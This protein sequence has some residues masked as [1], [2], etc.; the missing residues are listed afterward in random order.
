LLERKPA[1][2]ALP[3]RSSDRPD[4]YRAVTLIGPAFVAAI[5]YVDPGNLATD[6]TG[7]ARFGYQLVW[8]VVLANLMAMLVQYL[9]AKLGVATGKNLAELCRDRYRTPV[10]VF[11]WV[12]AELV[13]VMTDLAEVIGGAL[14][15]QILFGVPLPVGGILT[16]IGVLPMMAA[17]QRGRRAYEAVIIGLLTVVLLAFVY[18]VTRAHIDL[19]GL[20]GGMVPRLGGA[21]GALL[22]CGII[23]ATV[24]PHA[25]YLH[26]GLT[27]R[28]SP[29]AAPER[30]RR[31]LRITRWDIVIALGV[32]GA[33]NL[34]IL[35]VATV[36]RGAEGD[37]LNAAHQAF[38]E[39]LG[40]LAGLCFGIA[41]LAS[42]LAASSVGIYSGQIVM[43][44]FLR[45]RIPLWLRRCVSLVPAVALLASGVDVTRALV[46]S[47]VALSFGLPFA[48]IPLLLITRDP[49]VMGELANRRLTTAVAT[50]IAALIIALNAYLVVTAFGL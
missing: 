33:V 43:Q 47:Q 40:G 49:A 44:G 46:V 19:G 2:V 16:A 10:R 36:L 3:S 8:V 20:A 15:L 4:G 14:G 30:R 32:A 38:I 1:A 26:G 24:M 18:Q 7:G 29:G 9:S 50:G 17:Q 12:Q 25:I 41:L 6:V 23:G 48:L 35:L 31:A 22:A 34:A 13:I 39:R 21:D 45:R 27:Q 5:A 37:T 42:G 28:L 11:L